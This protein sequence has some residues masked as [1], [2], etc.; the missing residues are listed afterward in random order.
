MLVIRLITTDG[1]TKK[2][3]TIL[4]LHFHFIIFK[5]EDVRVACLFVNNNINIY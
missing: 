1:T 2:K 5:N 3:K 4:E